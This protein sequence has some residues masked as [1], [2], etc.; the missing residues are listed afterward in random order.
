MT[1]ETDE[2]HCRGA[3]TCKVIQENTHSSVSPG[4]LSLSRW[5][6]MA[7]LCLFAL[8][9]SWYAFTLA[10]RL[11]PAP[12]CTDKASYHDAMRQIGLLFPHKK[13]GGWKKGGYGSCFGLST[14]HLETVKWYPQSSAE[15]MEAG[16]HSLFPPLIHAPCSFTSTCRFE[17][18]FHHKPLTCY[19]SEI[20]RNKCNKLNQDCVS[21]L[22]AV[23][24]RKD[25]MQCHHNHSNDVILE[26]R[27]A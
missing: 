13:G 26:R 5:A 16:Q 19:L 23:T 4:I 27:K 22:K 6:F 25:P 7:E 15:G 18:P 17:Y 8:L 10:A 20:S 2:A 12:P 9:W 11:S 3:A 1:K 21:F 14:F 24:L